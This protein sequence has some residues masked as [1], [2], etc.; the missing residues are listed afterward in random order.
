MCFWSESTQPALGIS[1]SHPFLGN[2]GDSRGES[3]D[4][5][6]NHRIMHFVG[7]NLQR[8]Q[9]GTGL[10]QHPGTACVVW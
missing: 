1:Q 8:Q 9:A 4:W 5:V 6:G 2:T 7:L 3:I 10:R